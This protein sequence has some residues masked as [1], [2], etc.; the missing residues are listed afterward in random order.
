MANKIQFKRG[1]KNNLPSSANAGEPIFG[2]NTN[3]LFVG[4]GSGMVN[5]SGATIYEGTA[6]SGTS[7][8]TGAY[9]YSACP[10]VK[11][12]DI[13]RNTGN[14]NIY[15]CTTAGSGTTAKWTY[16]GTAAANYIVAS[17][18]ELN[19]AVTAL[20]SSTYGGKIILREGS[21]TLST[22]ATK[23]IIFEGMGQGVTFLI[24]E[25]VYSHTSDVLITI[26]NMTVTQSADLTDYGETADITFN[27][28]YVKDNGTYGEM[29]VLG[30]STKVVFNECYMSFTASRSHDIND[31]CNSVFR[32]FYSSGVVYINGGELVLS[33]TIRKTCLLSSG[34]IPSSL[35]ISGH[36][37]ITISG[38]GV[39]L[40]N[41]YYNINGCDITLTN[42]SSIT[43]D[44]SYDNSS[45][46]FNGNRVSS[47]THFYLAAS[48][49]MG[50]IFHF[51]AKKTITLPYKTNFTNNTFTGLY[52]TT[53]NGL[54]TIQR[55]TDN[56]SDVELS[57]TNCL[58]GS[59]T[60]GN[61][62][63]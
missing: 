46:I 50:N 13:Y 34:N 57:V 29:F 43:H 5:V 54:N 60:T 49:V 16:K 26:N 12:G 31:S 22:L 55:V 3:E 53:I 18:A 62:V 24:H 58:S 52:T 40:T 4:T 7:T 39:C 28:C 36:T 9:S 10:L 41:G 6:M 19:A 59:V 44:S 45:S 2:T 42:S 25:N 63:Y 23:N 33:S 27:Y 17:T 11:V 20:N 56:F 15:K 14:G 35:Y 37:K 32:T 48:V 30:R 47:G 51:T 8:T 61:T 38:G 1:S 21:Y